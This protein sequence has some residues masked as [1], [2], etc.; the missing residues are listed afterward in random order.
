M[1]RLQMP[2]RL[3]RFFFLAGALILAV[4]LTFTGVLVLRANQPVIELFTADRLRVDYLLVEEGIEAVNMSWKAVNL[5]DSHRMRMEAW[6][7]ERWVLIGEGFAPE[8]SDRIVVS[9]PLSFGQPLYRLSVLDSGDQI[10]TEKLLELDY[11]E[12]ST[13]PQI[14]Q[15]IAP[16]R[17][18]ILANALQQGE[19]T[20]PLI[21]RIQD[22]AYA[23]QPVFE[24][25][26][27]PSGEVV[28]TPIHDL[29]HWLPRQGETTMTLS[30]VEGDTIFIR[31]RVM[32]RQS[33]ALLIEQLITLPVIEDIPVAIAP[34]EWLRFD[35]ATQEHVSDILTTGQN[36]DNNPNVVLKIGD[37]NI[38]NESVLCNFNRGNYDLGTYTHL[39][40]VI[41]RFAGSFCAETSAAMRSLSTTSVLD[42]MWST[43][44]E[45][46]SNETPLAC[47]VRL[48]KPS[49]ALIY[50]GVQ[51]LERLAQN[52]DIAAESYYSNLE[53]IVSELEESCVV[54]ILT[55]FPTGYT[56]HNDGTADELN[57]MIRELAAAQHLPLIDLR[58]YTIHYPNRGVDVDGF[59]M[60]TPPG[61]RTSFTG[62]EML[63]ARTLYELLVLEM[64][65]L[66]H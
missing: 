35:E 36:L 66:L 6:V 65:N 41:D 10:V 63:Y 15:F 18:G 42:P 11:N 4:A 55:T 21:W 23:H 44:A 30:P 9:H 16:V 29:D 1:D 20:V 14:A 60:S 51:D 53:N 17:G 2:T 28:G 59:H 33:S 61:G 25:V 24:Q 45:C 8:K 52:P 56:F 54:A 7:G 27:M 34:D 48:Q 37:S 57:D 49:Y 31:M 47:A 39:Q 19:V 13:Q 5:S 62:N 12:S 58:A 64:L 38:A 26:L 32:D 22:R 43:A 40:P 3:P 46:Q 50:L